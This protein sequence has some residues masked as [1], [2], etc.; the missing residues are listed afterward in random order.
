MS[1]VRRALKALW[2]VFEA[3]STARLPVVRTTSVPY[4]PIAVT[5]VFV[6]PFPPRWPLFLILAA[7]VSRP[8]FGKKT[9]F[10]FPKA[11]L[12][13]ASVA[14]I[15]SP[16]ESY[17]VMNLSGT[18]GARCKNDFRRVLVLHFQSTHPCLYG[19]RLCRD[20]LCNDGVA[21]IVPRPYL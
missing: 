14:D 18:C 1:G 7:A 2:R 15:G 11:G 19:L 20:Q 9:Q 21:R 4:P 6:A 17:P 12:R 16:G 3:S 13:I 5:P 8:R 10:S